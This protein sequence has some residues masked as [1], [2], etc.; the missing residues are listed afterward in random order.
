MFPALTFTD[1]WSVTKTTLKTQKAVQ[2]TS[3][4]YLQLRVVGECLGLLVEAECRIDL[5]RIAAELSGNDVPPQDD[6]LLVVAVG[7]GQVGHVLLGV[8]EPEE[9]G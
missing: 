3:P 1:E 9:A 5:G 8:G 7:E 4:F 6:G 2:A